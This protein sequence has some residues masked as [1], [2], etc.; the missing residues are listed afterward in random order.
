MPQDKDDKLHDDDDITDETE[1]MSQY[2]EK[3]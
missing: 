2:E 1:D 3:G